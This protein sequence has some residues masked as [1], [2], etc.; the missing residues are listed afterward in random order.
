MHDANMT[1][2]VVLYAD[3]ITKEEEDEQRQ[4]QERTLLWCRLLMEWSGTE[5]G[6]ALSFNFQF[7]NIFSFFTN[8]C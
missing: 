1:F 7:G 4:E 6:T 5:V 8:Y 3:S 2:A